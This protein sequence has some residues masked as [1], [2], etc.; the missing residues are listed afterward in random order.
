MENLRFVKDEITA[1]AFRFY[2]IDADDR[3]LSFREVVNRWADKNGDGSLFRAF[4][5]QV[6]SGVP[7]QA[8][9]WETP[10]V[11]L[12]RF[13]LQFEFVVLDDPE[14][15]RPEDR[16]AF[17]RHFDAAA[18]NQAVVVFESLGRDA[19]L[20][21]PTP[22]GG[23]VNH[24]H[25]ASF[26][27]TC[28]ARQESHLWYHVGKAMLDRVSDV[29]VWLSTAG[30]GVPWLHMRLDSTPKYYGCLLYTSPSPR[31]RTRSRMPSSA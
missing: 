30:G 8:Y 14:L 24:C 10:V 5:C 27:H 20:V 16:S 7:F 1:K 29:P 28:D 23:H 19:V 6:L 3:P 12:D 21:A 25:L 31:D 13:D 2:Y 15:D 11:D 22:G 4:H 9:R 18:E 26:L 17:S